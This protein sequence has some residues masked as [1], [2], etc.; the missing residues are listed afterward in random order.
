MRKY[1]NITKHDVQF[2]IFIFDSGFVTT[3]KGASL[4]WQREARENE[5]VIK[6]FIGLGIRRF[7]FP[8]I[9]IQMLLF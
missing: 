6:T 4:K 2:Q 7:S 1:E 5:N 8:N 9:N 3:Q